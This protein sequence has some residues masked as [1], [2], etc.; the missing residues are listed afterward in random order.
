MTT[1]PQTTAAPN[2]PSDKTSPERLAWIV[3]LLSFTAF[4][5]T[6]LIVTVGAYYFVFQS[7]VPLEA[8][9]SVGRGT[10]GITTSS[11]RDYAQ[12]ARPLTFGTMLQTDDLSQATISF[13]DPQAQNRVVAVVTLRRASTAV[14]A[15]TNRPRFDWNTNGYTATLRDFSGLADVDIPPAP[16]QNRQMWLTL[17]TTDGT[18]IYLNGTGRYTVNAEV[19]RV[20]VVNR[21]GAATLIVQG[22]SG[23]DIPSGQVGEWNS[24][25]N[26]VTIHPAYVDLL[27]NADFQ[28]ADPNSAT[29]L[30]SVWMC[31]A[32]ADDPAEPLGMFELTTLDGRN[33]LQMV[34]DALSPGENRCVQSFQPADSGLDVRA[35][36]YLAL[37]ATLRINSQSLSACGFRASECPLM[38]RIDYV[39]VNGVPRRWFQ[40][41]YARNDASDTPL[42][43]DSCTAEHN[44]INMGAW[45]SYDTQNLYTLF[46]PEQRPAAILNIQ[47]YASGHQYDVNVSE[48]ALLA[49]QD[50]TANADANN[51]G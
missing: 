26:A 32:G 1:P 25:A 34:K 20:E 39:D 10:V 11:T 51:G 24:T 7:N 47:F 50:P 37:R 22:R 38:L 28:Q 44:R 13:L 21:Q 40:G 33:T 12:T 19:G 43:C 35:Y 30:P 42:R 5:A 8:V 16:Q 36:T 6:C 18:A 48:V 31:T 3:L 45:F 17:L 15:D 41:F 23:H 4:C 27:Q 29:P 2:V 49:S 46:P 9:L 14:L